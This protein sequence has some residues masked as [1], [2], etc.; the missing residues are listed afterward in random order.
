LQ[1][2]GATGLEGIDELGRVS[3]PEIEAEARAAVLAGRLRDGNLRVVQAEAVV[4]DIEVAELLRAHLI[5][6]PVVVAV[7]QAADLDALPERRC[8]RGGRRVLPV[9][10]G[11]GGCGSAAQVH[12][13]GAEPG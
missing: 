7:H 13:Q 8:R 12:A 1:V 2:V 4:G 5:E 3:G 9:R 6:V 11:P 10:V